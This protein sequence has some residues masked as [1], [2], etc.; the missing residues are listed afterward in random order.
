MVFTS[1]S[2]I[3][4]PPATAGP[5]LPMWKNRMFIRMAVI[6]PMVM[7]VEKGICRMPGTAMSTPGSSGTF[8]SA[9]LS[10]MV[11]GADDCENW[12]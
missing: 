9:P 2:V 8:T 10:R 5:L 7:P 11:V 3:E 1:S 4:P 6:A 12:T